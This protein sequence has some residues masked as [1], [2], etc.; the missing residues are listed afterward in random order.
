MLYP[1]Q[2]ILDYIFPPTF[3]EL[4]LRHIT[5]N[6]FITFYQPNTKNEITFLSPY[7]LPSIQAA[8]VACK[9]EH[10]YH[11]AQLLGALV[12]THLN[13]LPR[14]KT[15]LIP[16]PLSSIRERERGFNQVARVLS[17]IRTKEFL[18][19][20]TVNTTILKRTRD[21]KAQTTLGRNERLKNIENAFASEEI[22]I[23][24]FEGYERII[25]CDDVYTTG[26]TLKAARSALTHHLPKTTELYLLAWAH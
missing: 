1:F 8:I 26:S 22:N 21:T 15:L 25:L 16:V 2:I 7:H 10:N 13:T 12:S 23:H 14:K 9:F 4:E 20:L 17:Y 24:I 6:R 3:H 18:Y 19:P 11:A 5:K